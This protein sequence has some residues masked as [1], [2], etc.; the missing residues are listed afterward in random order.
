M[1]LTE[2][3]MTDLIFNILK[4]P[5]KCCIELDM[6]TGRYKNKVLLVSPNTDLTQALTGDSPKIFKQH[7]MFVT[8]I[9]NKA[10]KVTFKG[11]PLTVPNE[12]ILH[13]AEH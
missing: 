2:T 8:I 13:L 7:E 12:E 10:T 3:H 6:Q 5:A 1:N 9:S 4:I 11:V